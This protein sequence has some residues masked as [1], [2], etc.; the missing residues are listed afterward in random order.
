LTLKDSLE[1][2]LKRKG[3]IEWIVENNNRRYYKITAK[4]K[5]LLKDWILI[6]NA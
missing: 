1:N 4:G 5:K 3:K 2:S 6:L